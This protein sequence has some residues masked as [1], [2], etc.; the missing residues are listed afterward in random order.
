MRSHGTVRR[1]ECKVPLGDVVMTMHRVPVMGIV[2]RLCV[3]VA[4]SSSGQED[5]SAISKKVEPSVVSVLIY[6]VEGR[7]K[8]F[9]ENQLNHVS[10]LDS[11]GDVETLTCH[12]IDIPERSRSIPVKGF[13]S[14]GKVGSANTKE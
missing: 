12:G 11:F 8:G 4:S 9:A 1:R 5:G 14:E 6:D 2:L 7:D 13:L 10:D 3:A